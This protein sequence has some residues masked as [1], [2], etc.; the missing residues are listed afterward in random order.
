MG[1]SVTLTKEQEVLF[2]DRY[3]SGE[4]LKTLSAEIGCSV[5][6]LRRKLSE[7]GVRIRARGRPKDRVVNTPTTVVEPDLN[8]PETEEL[9][10]PHP[11]SPVPG[12]PRLRW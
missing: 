5:P 6:T 11:A 7:L 2:K 4:S 3:V 8:V 12:D 10:V 1:K 9:Q